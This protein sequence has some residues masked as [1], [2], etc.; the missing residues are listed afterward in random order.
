LSF[1]SK[2]FSSKNDAIKWYKVFDSEEEAQKA[3]P[4]NKAVTVLIN[5]Q[6]LCL[7]KNTSGFFAT[8][9]ACPHLGAALSKG[10]CNNFGEIVCPWHSYRF[11]LKTGHETTGKGMGVKTFPVEIRENG[12]YI[13]FNG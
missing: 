13:G 1:L 8:E 4:M 10:N 9:D 7:A 11:N 2:I 12:L 3:I 6:K 5:N